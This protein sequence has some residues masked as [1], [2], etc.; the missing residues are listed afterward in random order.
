MYIETVIDTKAQALALLNWKPELLFWRD[1]SGIAQYAT[2]EK[3]D[4]TWGTVEFFTCSHPNP[5]RIAPIEVRILIGANA[6]AVIKEG[7]RQTDILLSA[8]KSAQASLREYANE[9]REKAER[10]LKMADLA[11]RAADKLSAGT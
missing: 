5:R 6:Y 4:S 10:L 3:V 7:A 2:K 11:E 1:S 9:Q 8:G